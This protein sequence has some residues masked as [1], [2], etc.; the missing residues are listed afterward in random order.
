MN[1]LN[2]SKMFNSV[3]N[4]TI[5]HSPEILTG[6]GIAG[7]ISTTV[8]A[9][10]ATPKALRLI[11]A[12]KEKRNNKIKEE[13]KESGNNIVG[14]ID[15]ISVI[16]TVKVA[17]KPFIPAAITGV[18]SIACIIGSNSVNL[19]RNAALATAYQLSTTALNEYKEKVV[20][21]IG[22]KKEETIRKAIAK[23][24]VDK[25]PTSNQV[26]ITG[27][28]ESLF[29]DSISGRYFKS[30]LEKIKAA[31]NEM[32]RNM[33]Y[34]NYVSLSDFYD[35]IGLSHTKVSDDLGWNLDGGFIDIHYDTAMSE[36]GRPCIVLDYHI[37]PRYDF[38]K[39]M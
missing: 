30:D 18:T 20:E 28:G 32:N 17:W 37:A 5:K 24:K 9:V 7:M 25:N 38:T 29:L 10:K 22:E 16:D 34:D 8:L 12:E 31:V 23:D 39:L 3:K 4:S 6:I 13:V 21:T 36:D 15:R 11:E 26:V 1:K 33:T 19:K 27:S 35:E 2:L 14:L